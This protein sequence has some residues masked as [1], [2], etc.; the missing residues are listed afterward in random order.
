MS[1]YDN[2]QSISLIKEQILFLKKTKL[3]NKITYILKNAISMFNDIIE[4]STDKEF[5]E[6][7][8]KND[9]LIEYIQNWNIFSE[10]LKKYVYNDIFN[11]NLE[12]NVL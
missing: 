12:E 9:V 8:C 3:D 2:N 11:V 7:L 4:K 5:V 1:D 6:I 10:K